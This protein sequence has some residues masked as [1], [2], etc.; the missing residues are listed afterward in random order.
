MSTTFG[1]TVGVDGPVPSPPRY[2]LLSVARINPPNWLQ[3]NQEPDL[4][5]LSGVE[6]WPYPDARSGDVHNPCATGTTDEKADQQEL[7]VPEFGSFAAYETIEC[8]TRSISEDYDLWAA[9]AVAALQATES[10]QVEV[11]FARGLRLPLTPHLTDSNVTLV[12]NTG[13]SPERAL[14]ALVQSAGRTGSEF[15]VHADPATAVALTADVLVEREGTDL[16]VI[17]TGSKVVVG[18]G[19]VDSR[20]AGG[21]APSATLSWMYATGPVDVHRS[22]IEVIPGSAREAMDRTQNFI[23]IRAERY[24]VVD[25]DTV[26]QDAVL[27]NRAA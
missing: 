5:Y 27:V 9:R 24:Y 26:L 19:Y 10:Y 25:W 21:L 8:S 3:Q 12:D 1:P 17:A 23:T 15:V 13:L 11:Q 14:A 18:D 22:G 20:P 2:S 4:H 16:R 6:V 7:P